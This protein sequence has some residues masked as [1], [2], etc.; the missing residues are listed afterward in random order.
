[1]KAIT[2]NAAIKELP[3]LVSLTIAN[4]ESTLIVT[5]I[6]NVVMIDERDYRS[7]M[8]TIQ[9]LSDKSILSSLAESYTSHKRG[10]DPPHKTF[11]EFFG[12]KL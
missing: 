7:L 2:L 8:D 1:M 5:D 6:G 10:E 12:E 3:E 4:H 9:V 11:E